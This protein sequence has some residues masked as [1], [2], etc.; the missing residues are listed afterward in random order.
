MATEK[1][2]VAPE[3]TDISHVEEQVNVQGS[4]ETEQKV[5]TAGKLEALA[6]HYTKAEEKRYL[7]KI[8][9]IVLGYV[10]GAYLLAYVSSSSTVDEFS[11]RPG[12][13]RWVDDS[14]QG[15]TDVHRWTVAISEMQIPQECQRTSASAT[16]NIN[17]A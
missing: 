17:G 10:S 8:D 7:T 14:G 3:K 4:P 9:I 13:S 2:H 6:F 12:G 15:L 11:V 5:E 16:A 1:D